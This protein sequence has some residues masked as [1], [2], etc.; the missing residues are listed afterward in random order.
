MKKKIWI[1]LLLVYFVWGSTYLGIRFA[2]ETIPPFLH[3]AVRFLI[4]G[5]ILY[6]WRRMA[7]D[8]APTK[9]QWKSALIIGTCLI[10]FGNGLIALAETNIP[11]G[12]AALLVATTP[13]FMVIVEALRPGGSKPTFVQ[14][15]ALLIGFG[16]VALLIGPAEFGGTREFSLVSGGIVIV[17]SIVWSIGSIYNRNADLPKSS[18]LFSGMEMLMGCLGLFIVSIFK[19]EWAGFQITAI[20]LRSIFGLLY[21]I[22]IGSLVGF[23]SYAWLLRNAPISLLSTYPYVNPIVAVLLGALFAQEK[24][25]PR[26]IISAV[27][28]VGSIILVNLSNKNNNETI[29]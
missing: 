14:I 1:A 6:T 27:I 25:T 29:Q 10:L 11:S 4:A 12:V 7:G 18:L 26:L 3:A 2:V 16:G 22:M 17:A 15:L 21:L 23:T 9:N 20:S 8:P 19:G 5:T 13:M 24:I 28:I